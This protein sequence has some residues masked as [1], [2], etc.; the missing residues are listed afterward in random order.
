MVLGYQLSRHGP[1]PIQLE[2]LLKYLL[3]VPGSLPN[4][5]IARHRRPEE[6][7]IKRNPI[8]VREYH[9][10]MLNHL[11]PLQIGF[12]LSQPDKD[13]LKPMLHQVCHHSRYDIARRW[14]I[15]RI[16]R[17]ITVLKFRPSSIRIPLQK[18]RGIETNNSVE[19]GGPMTAT[20]ES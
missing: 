11:E 17:P 12:A 5:Q 10:L 9:Q 13:N 15:H 3:A 1:F 16:I 4:P 19:T 8:Q 18:P 7:C 2:Y 20:I 6:K 14:G